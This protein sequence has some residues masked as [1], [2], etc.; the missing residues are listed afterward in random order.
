VQFN[1]RQFSRES[2]QDSD[3]RCRLETI[4]LFSSHPTYKAVL[5]EEYYHDDPEV[6]YKVDMLLI[7]RHTGEHEQNLEVEMKRSWI[8]EFPFRDI[9]FLP[10]KAEKWSDPRFTYGKPTHWVL[11]NCDATQHLVV[12]DHVIRNLTEKRMV[13]CQVR[14]LEELYCIP[15]NLAHLNYLD[16]KAYKNLP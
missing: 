8:D 4:R 9:Q 11:F 16:E 2:H 13:N 6:M 15:K 5:A 12:F 7:N 3:L 14:G 1:P 10:R